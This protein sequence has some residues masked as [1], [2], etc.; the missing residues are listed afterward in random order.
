MK[1]SASRRRG[2]DD[3]REQAATS[4]L[5][6]STCSNVE[7]D[8]EAAPRMP[9]SAAPPGRQTITIS[10]VGGEPVEKLDHLARS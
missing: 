2:A 6:P 8:S 5:V 10:L 9:P 3:V 7:V 1:R 4:R